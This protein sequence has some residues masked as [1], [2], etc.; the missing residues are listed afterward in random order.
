[1]NTSAANAS[2]STSKLDGQNA[3]AAKTV[4][5]VAAVARQQNLDIHLLALGT[6]TPLNTVTVRSRVEGQLMS[7]S[8]EEGQLVKQ[9]DLLALIDPR[10][11]EVQ[12]A[13]ANGQLARDQAIL[14]KA[15]A[16]LTRYQTLLKQESISGQLVDNQASLVRQSTA[17]V[18]TS[19]GNVDNA[20]LQLSYTRITAPISGR[21]GLHL[22]GAGN[23]VRASDPNGIAT[24]T[25]LQPVGVVFSIPEDSL[26]RI[27]KL[28]HND[29]KIPVEAFDRGQKEKLGKGRL[30]AADNQIDSTTGTIKLKAEFA[31]TEGGLFANQFVNIKIPVETRKNA[32][33]IPSAAIQRGANGAFVYVVKADKSVTVTPVIVGAIQGEMT[34][35]NSGITAGM[36]VVIEGA[37]G[38][39]EG[40]KVSVRESPAAPNAPNTPNTPNT[41]N[42]PG[43]TQVQGQANTKS[44]SAA[45]LNSA[46]DAT[47]RPA[48]KS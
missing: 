42:A 18:Q 10:P 43:T 35:I 33:V 25:Q 9:G 29:E 21:L 11:F 47:D 39:R 12:L 36:Q 28:L 26:P 19:Q 6:V 14:E 32:I 3:L 16:D 38:L 37:D 23:V 17:A 30:L 4:P 5:V 46:T 15:E 2:Q 20:K 7:V 13:L 24:I 31:N 45:K 27:M 34:S 48:V 22:I 44:N 41:P 1:K 40:S 8:F